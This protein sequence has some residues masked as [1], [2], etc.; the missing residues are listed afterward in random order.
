MYSL[1]VQTL[2]LEGDI[3]EPI[4]QGEEIEAKMPN[5]LPK[6]TCSGVSKDGNKI[7]VSCLPGPRLFLYLVLPSHQ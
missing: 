4:L 7:Q 5:V 1:E 2:E 6:V 3:V